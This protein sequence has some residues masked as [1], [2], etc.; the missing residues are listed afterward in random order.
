VI[1]VRALMKSMTVADLNVAAEEL[2]SQLRDY[3]Y[4]LGRPFSDTG[5]APVVLTC[6][7]QV[8]CGLSLAP[9]MTVVDVGAGACWA[10]RALA[11]F[12]LHAI[13]LEVSSTALRI[14]RE[15]FAKNPVFGDCPEPRFLK[16]DG[17]TIDL[18]DSSVDR[19]ICLD[20]L[21]HIRNPEHM[22]REMAR[23]LKPGGVAGLSE[24][25]PDHSKTPHAQYAMRAYKVLE[26]DINI[27]EIWE[28]AQQAGFVDM[29]VAIFAYPPLFA[30]VDDFEAFLQN[31]ECDTAMREKYIAATL[32]GLVHHRIFFL[33]RAG[34]SPV[35]SRQ[36]T[37][38]ASELKVDVAAMT[39]R[40]GER[41]YVHAD[42]RNVGS[43]V[44]LP[45]TAGIGAVNIGAHLWDASD[46][47][48]E[49]DY[50]RTPLRD[51]S[52]A[53]EPNTHLTL[54]FEVPAPSKPGRYVIEFDLVSE[55]I[56]WFHMAGSK[57]VRVE[58]EVLG[59]G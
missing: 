51:E 37:A 54:D 50:F 36:R 44:W 57:S 59:V 49:N 8:L 38:L 35:D 48:I 1:D 26:N 21:H 7:A 31:S 2:Y 16:F 32:E 56:T 17:M 58:F 33:T 47:L 28:W 9:G 20:V 34:K 43:A 10:T 4:L 45:R 12:G 29:K 55:G 3:N 5:D 14:G 11:Q 53:V 22:L 24:P 46:R 19:T 23:I 13:A 25:G 27:R 42:V 6:L 39:V 41:L 30:S 52:T 18:P 40:R 15:L